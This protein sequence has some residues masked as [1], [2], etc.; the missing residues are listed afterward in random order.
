MTPTFDYTEW[1][2]IVRGVT[3]G[4][5]QVNDE[6]MVMDNMWPAVGG[7][8]KMPLFPDGHTPTK[9]EIL[10]RWPSMDIQLVQ[11][12]PVYMP[13][14]DYGILPS[15]DPMQIP[16]NRPIEF[17]RPMPLFVAPPPLGPRDPLESNW[18]GYPANPGLV[19]P[20][21]PEPWTPP[22]EVPSIDIPL[23][24]G[25]RP[26][27]GG[28]NKLPPGRNEKERKTR[29]S[30]P[31]AA[32]LS[33]M[34]DVSDVIDAFYKSIPAKGTHRRWKGRD[35]KWRE[36]AITPQDKLLFIF[37]NAKEMDL[38]KAIDTLIQNEIEDRIIGGI[39][40][41]LKN[42]YDRNRPHGSLGIGYQ[43]GPAL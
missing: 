32:L 27:A 17:P 30:L 15:L 40:Q 42:T 13:A 37:K 1:V 16:I 25:V 33:A 9:A 19:A 39:S 7:W 5:S 20:T 24:P 34:T 22:Y 21:R 10:A 23:V 28:H 36:A 43:A 41:G 38:D 14:E 31:A 26:S 12:R 8:P 3:F 2:I 18:S 11:P 4:R 29:R 6:R 35:G